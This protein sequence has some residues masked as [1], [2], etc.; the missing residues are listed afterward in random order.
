MT[1]TKKDGQIDNLDQPTVMR[2]HM[3]IALSIIEKCPHN[4][5]DGK[6]CFMSKTPQYG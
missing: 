1:D 2:V 6:V 5:F 4:C 3:A